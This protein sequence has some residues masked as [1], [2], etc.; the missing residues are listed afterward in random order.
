MMAPSNND[1]I[2]AAII[3]DAISRAG[4][5]KS[6]PEE[7]KSRDQLPQQAPARKRKKVETATG[8]CCASGAEIVKRADKERSC[9]NALSV[10]GAAFGFDEH[11][12]SSELTRPE[13][14]DSEL[15]A[16]EAKGEQQGIEDRSACDPSASANATLQPYLYHFFSAPQCRDH[17]GGG[18]FTLPSQLETVPAAPQFSQALNDASCLSIA[19][20]APVQPWPQEDLAL[21]PLEDEL[22]S[23]RAALA[24]SAQREESSFQMLKALRIQLH[25]AYR[26]IALQQRDLFSSD[27]EMTPFPD[28]PQSAFSTQQW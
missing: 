4:L 24:L 19:Q 12:T 20:Q 28:S 5:H 2:R 10:E 8:G 16:C 14:V 15:G 18:D 11:H 6:G 23:L 3:R 21:S 7:G 26:M 25:E 1:A 17:T 9:H 27:L 22:V 13:H